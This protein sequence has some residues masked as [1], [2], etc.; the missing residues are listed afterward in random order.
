MKSPHRTDTA[1]IHISINL[2]ARI[3]VK[4]VLGHYENINIHLCI[5]LTER[6][7]Q[8]ARPFTVSALH[9]HSIYIVYI[10]H[11]L[12]ILL[13]FDISPFYSILLSNDSNLQLVFYAIF[14]ITKCATSFCAD[15]SVSV[16]IQYSPLLSV[17]LCLC[18][19]VCV[20]VLSA[21]FI[22]SSSLAA[23]ASVTGRTLNVRLGHA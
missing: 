21:I 4:L 23:W 15:F 20:S 12:S 14:S 17:R 3:Q 16:H 2:V 9:T 5:C 6:F 10:L 19:C 13:L 7:K 18:A 11:I 22:A 8:F 1:Y